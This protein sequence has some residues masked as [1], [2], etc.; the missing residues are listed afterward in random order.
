MSIL[1]IKRKIESSTTD[2]WPLTSMASQ[3]RTVEYS[4]LVTD[5]TDTED[6]ILA[7]PITP[8]LRSPHPDGLIARATRRQL[9]RVAPYLYDLEVGYEAFSMV[10][11]VSQGG[12]G[13]PLS[14]PPKIRFTSTAAEYEIDVDIEGNAIIMRTGEEFNPKPKETVYDPVIE[15]TRNVAWVNPFVMATYRN[16][17]N[18]DTWY[19][20]PPGTLRIAGLDADSV[21]E[22]GDDFIYWTVHGSIQCRLAHPGSTDDKAWWL[23]MRAQGYIVNL[24]D[25]QGEYI[26]VHAWDKEGNK[27]SKPVL[28]NKDTGAA[29]VATG[30]QSLNTLAQ[31][32]EFQTKRS[33]PFADLGLL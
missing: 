28:H 14:V 10:G 20:M 32:Y 27:V 26:A 21:G 6:T 16:A 33:L 1:N 25:D 3:E 17:T 22:E 30:T 19:G 29:I 4:V 24:T 18:S 23:R 2:N 8:Q 7:S 12:G 11:D 31:W 5:T 13:N 9:R 15:I